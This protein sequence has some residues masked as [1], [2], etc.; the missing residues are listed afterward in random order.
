MLNLFAVT[1]YKTASETDFLYI[2]FLAVQTLLVLTAFVCI[3]ILL[4]RIDKTLK[5]LNSDNAQSEKEQKSVAEPNR[6][7]FEKP[8]AEDCS[9]ATAPQDPVSAVSC[10]DLEEGTLR[11][12]KSFLARYIQSDDELKQRYSKLKNTILS[13]G[14]VK[15]R[16]SWKRET[17]KAGRVF[18]ARFAFRGKTLCLFLPDGD[19]LTEYPLEAVERASSYAETPRLLRIKNDRRFRMACELIDTVATNLSLPRTERIAVDYYLPFEETSQLLDKGLVKCEIK[20]VEDEAIF[21]RNKE[22][23]CPVR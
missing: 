21:K 5:R 12:D 20:S 8:C 10:D 6:E 4:H 18:V 9:V 23:D 22:I 11:Y 3:L 2:L 15:S 16:S 17:F 1:S 7:I 19:Y 14:G 13:Y